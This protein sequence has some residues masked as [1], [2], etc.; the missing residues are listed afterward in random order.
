MQCYT[1]VNFLYTSINKIYLIFILNIYYPR[2]QKF[3]VYLHQSIFNE[4]N[5]STMVDDMQ[6]L[7]CLTNHINNA[8]NKL[9][10]PS[11]Q[12]EMPTFLSTIFKIADCYNVRGNEPR[13]SIDMGI[14]ILVE[15][16]TI[17]ITK[18]AL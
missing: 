8:N 15:N 18:I 14:D 1:S 7:T 17:D 10:I 3:L 11:S 9:N 12:N 5:S 4:Q 13:I 16:V 6:Q 2:S